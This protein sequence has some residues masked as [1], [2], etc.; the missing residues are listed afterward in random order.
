MIRPAFYLFACLA[1]T[2]VSV[3]ADV[4]AQTTEDIVFTEIETRIIKEYFDAKAAR[5]AE[6]EGRTSG[7]AHKSNKG[8]AH[9]AN[10]G[11]SKGLPPGLAKKESLPP[12]LAKQLS[13]RGT[14]PPGLAKR[15]LPADLQS[16]LPR[17]AKGTERVIVDNDVVLIQAATRKVLDVLFDAAKAQE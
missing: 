1:F 15:D 17:P 5:Q 6:A 14:L 8:K 10:K 2:C 3:S 13:E 9:K 16:R 4:T 11:K 7:K 12:G